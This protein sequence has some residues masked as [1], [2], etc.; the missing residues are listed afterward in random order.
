[1]DSF[2]KHKRICFL[3]D[4]IAAGYWIDDIFTAY[5]TLFSHSHTCFYNCGISGG[6]SGAALMY[7]QD[8]LLR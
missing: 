1:M 8:N 7:W 6:I 4:S 3:G 5:R 2:S